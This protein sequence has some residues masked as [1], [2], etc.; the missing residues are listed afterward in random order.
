VRFHRGDEIPQEPV[1][2]PGPTGAGRY[3]GGAADGVAVLPHADLGR[4]DAERRERRADLAAMVAPVMNHLR[5]PD[6]LR[7]AVDGAIVPVDLEDLV[8]VRIRGQDSW[9]CGGVALHRRPEV[10]QVHPLLFD[11]RMAFA[12]QPMEVPAVGADDVTHRLEDRT[13]RA[14][15]RRLELLGAQRLAGVDELIAESVVV[16]GYA[17]LGESVVDQLTVGHH[18][19]P[20]SL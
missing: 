3:L 13:E 4:L 10:N 5:Q 12:A 15:C 1:T 2:V 9:P 6:A 17:P 7:G 8:G 18:D 20:P 14:R 19:T 16:L 11:R